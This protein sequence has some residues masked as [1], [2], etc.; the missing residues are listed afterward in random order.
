MAVSA[1]M[2]RMRY[3]VTAISLVTC[4]SA[5]AG[6]PGI[7]LAVTVGTD[8]SAGACGNQPS[9]SVMTGT[10]VNYCYVVTNQS[11]ETMNFITAE[12]DDIGRFKILEPHA[13][14]PGESYQYNRI[15]TALE[16]QSVSTTWTAFPI[17]PDYTMAENVPDRVFADGFD[18][19]AGDP[20]FDF[21]EIS[22]S[23]TWLDIDPDSN[24]V[25]PVSIGFP[26]TYYG[27]T[28]DQVGVGINGG[29][30]FGVASGYLNYTPD[31]LPSV[32]LGPAILPWWDTFFD[33]SGAVYAQTFGDAPDRTFVVEWKDNVHFPAT[34]EGVT[35]ELVLHE[36]T[37][38]IDFLYADTLFGDPQYDHG[39][40]GTVGLNSGADFAK[41]YSRNAAALDDGEIVRFEPTPMTSFSAT[42]QVSVTVGKPIIDVSPLAIDAVVAAGASTSAPLA[43]GNDGTLDLDWTAG[44]APMARA[45]APKRLQSKRIAAPLGGLVVP[46]FAFDQLPDFPPLVTFDVMQP[47]IV[48]P[49]FSGAR[50]I[51]GADFA[52]SDFGTLYA[53]DYWQQELLAVQTT[54]CG[55]VDQFVHIGWTRAADDEDWMSMHYDATSGRF[56][57]LSYGGLQRRTS[58]LLT[59]DPATGASTVVGAIGGIDDPQFGTQVQAIAVSPEGLIYG[60]EAV[61]SNLIAIDRV[62]AQATVIGSL[63]FPL[64]GADMDFDDATGTLYLLAGDANLQAES[65]YTVDTHTGFAQPISLVGVDGRSNAL[66]AFAIATVGPCTEQDDVPWLN[67][68]TSSGVTAP[69][70]SDDVAV[71]FDASALAAG[72]YRANVCIDSNDGAHPRVIVPVSLTVQ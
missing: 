69:G 38:A 64:A 51:A 57:G 20:T 50:R 29:L 42:A 1:T 15:A 31:V 40:W 65:T 59:I 32:P 27:I 19:S 10:F 25:V 3:A 9:I 60:V 66:S 48:M 72:T 12:Q 7:S 35:F 30:L 63:G 22:G 67:F 41:V 39:L 23:G 56:Y 8:V 52:G 24:A 37:N 70:A 26:F 2:F 61:G 44:E 34:P 54:D 5:G 16:S 71:G 21:V 6:E 68:D 49:I 13:L 62:T 45:I 43:I 53:L 55:C 28:S 17:A 33:S 47:S 58:H 4:L 11:G 36:T 14:A 18:D 46:A